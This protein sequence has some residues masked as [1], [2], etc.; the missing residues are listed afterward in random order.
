MRFPFA[1]LAGLSVIALAAP[2]IA[3]A[4]TLPVPAPPGVTAMPTPTP[5]PV[6]K[7]GKVTNLAVTENELGSLTLSWQAP[8]DNGSL[9][10]DDYR[11]GYKFDQYQSWLVWKHLPSTAT[12]I[13]IPDLPLGL[14]FSFSVRAVT[15]NASSL[16]VQVHATTP[17]PVSPASL[18]SRARAQYTFVASTWNATSSKRYGFLNG[19][20][21]A[22]WASQSLLL[23]GYRQNSTWHGSNRG[24]EP[25]SK[26][27]ISSTALHNYMLSS[28]R[29]TLLTDAQR[30][31]VSVGD[32]VQFDWW[33]KGAQEH[34]GVVTYIDRSATGIK[35][36]YASHTAA[37]MWWSV[38][39]SVNNVYPGAIAT[40]LHLSN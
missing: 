34:T 35:I 13:T 8:T 25:A 12:S 7:P 28:G 10:I 6:I 26:A 32:I 37:G 31:L 20:D 17:T 11:I 21:C 14:G 36:Y 30:D 19:T 33:N 24:G 16:A 5:I 3:V 38:N 39:R 9:P 2:A 4:E 15:A 1:I 40:Y 18:N 23:R 22:N 29:A 27:W